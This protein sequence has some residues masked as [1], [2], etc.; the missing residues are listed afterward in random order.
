MAEHAGNQTATATAAAPA[1]HPPAA[2]PPF[3]DAA[4]AR[5][6]AAQTPRRRRF[7][8]HEDAEAWHRARIR[9]AHPGIGRLAETGLL[10]V[11]QRADDAD[12][13]IAGLRSLDLAGEMVARIGVPGADIFAQLQH[14][15]R[16]QPEAGS[17]LPPGMAEGGVQHGDQT[18]PG[19]GDGI[20]NAPRESA[21]NG[22]V[23]AG[24]DA[25]GGGVEVDQTAHGSLP[26]KEASKRRREAEATAQFKQNCFRIA[27]QAGC[28]G[29]ELRQ[30]TLWMFE[31]SQIGGEDAR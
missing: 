29:E 21:D 15:L 14:L 3:P 20:Q 19:T 1:A 16:R 6:L 22:P 4:E 27:A 5:I 23:G 11:A 2:P 25:R 10:S 18:V 12:L 9:A 13:S 8:R 26:D 17:G 31:W 24:R 7:L 30:M 28:K